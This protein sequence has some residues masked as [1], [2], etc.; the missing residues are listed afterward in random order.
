MRNLRLLGLLLIAAAAGLL[1]LWTQS[2]GTQTVARILHYNWSSI[3]DNAVFPQ[4]TL[5]ASPDPARWTDGSPGQL[6]INLPP[7]GAFG[8]GELDKV[9]EA[10]DTVAF[11]VL[12]GNRVLLERYF[13]GYERTTPVMV[14]SVSKSILSLLIGMA[15]ED[16]LI[17]SVRQPVTDFIPEL[18]PQG[19]SEVTI[20]NLLQMTSGIDYT[21]NDNPLGE[22]VRLYYTDHLE[23]ELLRLTLGQAPG[24]RFEYRSSDALLLGL[25]LSR[26]L[27]D[28][29]ITEYT[30][31][32]LWDRLGME[33]EGSWG[34]DHAPDGLEKVGCCLSMTARDLARVGRL[35]LQGGKWKGEQVVPESW[36]RRPFAVETSDGASPEY[37]YMWW[38]PSAG[39]GAIMAK[40]Y[41]GQYLYLNPKHDIVIVRLGRSRGDLS[42]EA[43]VDLLTAIAEGASR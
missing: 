10:N 12:L 11:L 2:A 30:Q 8:G 40:G 23:D 39:S 25:I 18:A 28:Q 36:I 6:P 29:T 43:W 20:E 7:R 5:Q 21:E 31:Q 16:G 15:I 38:R 35:Y 1:L 4:R 9:L 17:A 34:I 19:F 41:L 22:H 13:Q 27:G 24:T 3:E 32:R 14:F 37:Q 42:D 33:G 26:A